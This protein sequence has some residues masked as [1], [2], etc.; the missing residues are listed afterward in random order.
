MRFV[1]ALILA[2]ILTLVLVNLSLLF[3]VSPLSGILFL[4]SSSLRKSDK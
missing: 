1:T 3:F 4:P 2:Q